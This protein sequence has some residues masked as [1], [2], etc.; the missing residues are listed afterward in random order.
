MG[1]VLIHAPDPRTPNLDDLHDKTTYSI[2]GVAGWSV[3]VE[4]T[5][6]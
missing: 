1:N 4:K 6:V 5:H 3:Q 2:V